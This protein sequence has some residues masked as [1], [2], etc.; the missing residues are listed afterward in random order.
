[1]HESGDPGLFFSEVTEGL[2]NSRFSIN[3]TLK[4]ILLCVLGPR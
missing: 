2:A 4:R 1:M 3:V